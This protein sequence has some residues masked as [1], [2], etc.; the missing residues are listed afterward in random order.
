MSIHEAVHKEK[1]FCI[2]NTDRPCG[3]KEYTK[4][5]AYYD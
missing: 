2:V 5:I 4:K 3:E 1:M